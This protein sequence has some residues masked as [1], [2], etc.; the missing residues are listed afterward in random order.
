M[1]PDEIRDIGLTL[2]ELARPRISPKQLFDAV[3]AHHP[4]AKRRDI[5][6]VALATMIASADKTPD[7]ATQLQGLAISQRGLD[8]D[9]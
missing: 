4:K 9:D 5:T 3:K 8:G 2:Q 7:L 6:R 1:K